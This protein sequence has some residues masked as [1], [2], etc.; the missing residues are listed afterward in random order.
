MA[1]AAAS[2][3]VGNGAVG[4]VPGGVG[5][6]AVR[7]E[8]SVSGSLRGFYQ[9]APPL[10]SGL[11]STDRGRATVGPTSEAA[12]TWNHLNLA[13][14]TWLFPAAAGPSTVT[15]ALKLAAGTLTTATVK[16]KGC[17]SRSDAERTIHAHLAEI[18][19]YM[20]KVAAPAA[21]LVLT[22]SIRADGSVADAHLVTKPK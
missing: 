10:K 16:V 15:V 13:A 8:V 22:L 2:S 3:V 1:F 7:E 20:E 6:Q 17:L 19:A 11:S 5:T 9:S 18:K 14:R 4:G 12:A 21:G